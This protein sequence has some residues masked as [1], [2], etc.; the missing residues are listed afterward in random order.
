MSSDLLL[1]KR[2][3]LMLREVKEQTPEICME[4]VRQNSWALQYVR[5]QT[6]EMCLMAVERDVNVLSFVKNLTPKIREIA[7]RQAGYDMV[8]Y[9]MTKYHF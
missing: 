2:D 9:A 7:S 3:G 1:V 5:E 4:A 6:E 8:C